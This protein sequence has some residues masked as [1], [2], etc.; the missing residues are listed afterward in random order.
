V[1]YSLVFSVSGA[2]NLAQGAFVALGA[3]TMY[4]FM[5]SAH[6]PVVAAFLA[7][8]CVVGAAIGIIEWV[9]IRRAVT[10]ISHASLLMMMGG[11]LTAFEGA[12]YLIWG[13]NPF[14][15]NQFSGSQP[16]RAGQLFIPTQGF[17]VIGAMLAS[18][19]GLAWLLARSRWGR[20]LRATSENM[21]AARLMGVPV[22]RMILLSFVAAAALGFARRAFDEALAHAKSRRMF[23]ATL[24]DLQL[25]QAAL[26][27]MAADID[28]AALLTYRA[29][30]RR[31]VQKLPTTVE[32]AM[33]KMT[34]TETAQRIIDRALQ[35]FGGRGVRRGEIVESLYR[36]IRALRIYEGATEVQ[37]LIVARELIKSRPS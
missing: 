29:A 37:K 10:R 24:A 17:W 8:V 7:S 31:D 36:E 27:E 26:G 2:L 6:L 32:A 9:V 30:W 16:V 4:T 20:G 23:G 13:A 25:T 1:G 12:A 34:A 33:A 21:T 15:F 19:A 14:A 3:L 11:L 18:V 22:D 35:M 5:N 28:A